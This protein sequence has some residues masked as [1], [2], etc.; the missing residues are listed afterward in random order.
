MRENRLHSEQRSCEVGFQEGGEHG[1]IM[2]K[3]TIEPPAAPLT[4]AAYH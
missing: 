2:G 4:F 1:D 3:Y